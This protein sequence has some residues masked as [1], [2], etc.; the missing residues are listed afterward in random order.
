MQAVILA[1]GKGTRLRPYT[2]TLPKPLVPV[3]DQPI[4]SIILRQLR[5]AG[6]TRVVLA[7][8][9]LAELIMAFFGNGEKFGLNVEYSVEDRPLGTIAPLKL[10]QDLPENFIVMNGDVLSDLNYQ[11]LYCKH[12]SNRPKLT[13]AT[14]RRSVQVDFGVLDIN[15]RN[16]LTGF[17]E[18]PTYELNVSMG[19]YVLNRAAL[20]VVPD[21]QAFGFDD[22]VLQLLSRKQRVEAHPHEGYW[23]DLGRPDDYDRASADYPLLNTR[24][25]GA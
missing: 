22:L 12:I 16:Q 24:C 6:V 14:Y 25:V 7:V 8:N 21:N 13:I 11:A 2:T 9:H 17:R 15:A 10:I 19:V 5:A 3:G 20:D 23:L 4:L 1:G 18:K